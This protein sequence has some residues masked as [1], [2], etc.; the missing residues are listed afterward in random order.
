MKLLDSATAQ[1]LNRTLDIYE[2]SRLYLQQTGKVQASSCF[3]CSGMEM[4]VLC[5]VKIGK[6]REGGQR[7]LG[8]IGRDQD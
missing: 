1:W 2:E 7:E 3:R 4:A 8:E 6:R 5:F